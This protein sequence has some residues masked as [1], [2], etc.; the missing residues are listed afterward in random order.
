M[1]Q[2]FDLI[3]YIFENVF[4]WLKSIPV[5]TNYITNTTVS[6]FDFS[7]G[8]IVMSLVIVAFVPLVKTGAYTYSSRGVSD[9][10]EVR[11]K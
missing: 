4:V 10:S 1:Q 9:E 3:F 6:L 8:I 2:V 11:K 7:I 5:F